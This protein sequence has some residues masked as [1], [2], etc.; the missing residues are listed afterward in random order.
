MKVIVQHHIVCGSEI[1]FT[2]NSYLYNRRQTLIMLLCG[3]V[4]VR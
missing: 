2:E 3:E 4:I 1:T